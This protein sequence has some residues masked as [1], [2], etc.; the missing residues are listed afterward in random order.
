MKL[1]FGTVVVACMIVTR[2]AGA[3]G[4]L[5]LQ[6]RQIQPLLD[7]LVLAANA[8]DTDRFLAP[9]AHD[10]TFIFVFNG[11]VTVGFDNIRAQQLKFWN[12]GQ[13][14]VAYRQTG[15]ASFTVL[16]PDIVLVTDPLNSRRTVPTGE[17]KSADVIVTMVWERRKEG[18]RIVQAH[19][20][21]LR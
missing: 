5:T 10:S 3:Q 20:S 12:N 8:H 9:Y 2:A 21:T 13:T 7:E 11:V 19:E 14:D 15:P 17:V 4:S 1:V 18:W 6:Q 16:T